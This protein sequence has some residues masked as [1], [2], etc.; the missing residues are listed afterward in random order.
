MP[1]PGAETLVVVVARR[2]AVEHTIAGPHQFRCLRI[3]YERRL[4]IH[5]A[6]L[7]R[8]C[9]LICLRTIEDALW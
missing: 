4:D 7:T 3:R 6:F 2:W 9:I 5:L 8:G 1:P